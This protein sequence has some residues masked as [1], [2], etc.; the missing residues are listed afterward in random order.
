MT[1]H[2]SFT[3]S[4]SYSSNGLASTVIPMLHFYINYDHFVYFF[5]LKAYHFHQSL[6]K[7]A[8]GVIDFL[9]TIFVISTQNVLFFIFFAF[10]WIS[11]VLFLCFSKV[12][13]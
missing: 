8:V 13:A 11:F 12:K 4:L 9:F 1:S 5:R 7:L 2:V 10:L 6:I 3:A